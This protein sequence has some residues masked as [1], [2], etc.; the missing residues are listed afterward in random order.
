VCF[1]ARDTLARSRFLAWVMRESGVVLVRRGA[2]EKSAVEAMIAHVAAGDCV[3]IFPEGTRSPDGSLGEFKPGALLV[4]RRARSP[5]VPC[6]IRGAFLAWPR[7][8]S[9]PRPS[10]I[11]IRFGPPI[12]PSAPGALDALVAAVASLAEDGRDPRSR[13]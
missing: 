7:G 13:R 8:R 10:P 5:I 9:L 2:A 12:D 3:A 4:A 11:S 6:A 1:A